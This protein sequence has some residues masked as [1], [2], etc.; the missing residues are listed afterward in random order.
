MHAHHICYPIGIPPRFIV[1][2]IVEHVA[3]PN[4]S[5]VG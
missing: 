5:S 4:E 1:G 2:R 3:R